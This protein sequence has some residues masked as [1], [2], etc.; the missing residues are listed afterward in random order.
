[1]GFFSSDYQTKVAT[2]VSRAVGD[3]FIPNSARK[4]GLKALV[5]DTPYLE[6]VQEELVN[7]IGLKAERLYQYGKQG[8]IFGL[9]SGNF[10]SAV[11]GR[12]QLTAVLQAIE[13]SPV[14]L[15]YSYFQRANRQHVV[16]MQLISLY[17]YNTTTNELEVL[18]SQRGHK[19]YL[20]DLMLVIPE[21]LVGTI[22]LASI[23]QWGTPANAAYSPLHVFGEITGA[24]RAFTPASYNP[25]VISPYMLV[26][27]SWGIADNLAGFNKYSPDPIET[28]QLS[29]PVPTTDDGFNYFQV[30]Y[31]VNGQKKYFMYRA[32]AG[33]YPTLDAVF[34]PAVDSN[35]DFFPF[36]YFRFNKVSEIANKTTSSYRAGK[37]LTKYLGINFDKIGTAI[38]ANPDIDK[39]EQAMLIMAV[40][41]V[42][43]DPLETRYLFS[44]FDG[45]YHSRATQHS[46][47]TNLDVAQYQDNGLDIRR[48][49]LVIQDARFKMALSNSGVIKRRVVANIG[50]VGTHTATYG[51]PPN[52]Q[53]PV[54]TYKHQVSS[55]LCDVIHVVNLT[56]EYDIYQGNLATGRGADGILLV[57]LDHSICKDYPIPDREKLYS[58]S[59]HY[60]FNSRVITEIKWYQSGLFQ[61]VMIVVAVLVTVFSFGSGVGAL[62]AALSAGSTAA[63][64]AAV[65]VLLEQLIIGLAI[66]IGLKL[67]VKS[68]GFDA[69]IFLALVAA[70]YGGYQS[71]QAGGLA[72][73][74]WASELLQL[75]SGLS[76]AI[77]DGLKSGVQDLIK[78]FESL[79]LLADTAS[80]S[81][82][83]ANKLLENNNWLS[84][85]VIFGEKPNDFYNRSIHSGNV[86]LISIGAISSYVDIALRLPKL[87]DTLGEHNYG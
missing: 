40:P 66:S 19:V 20:D 53:K 29:I 56:M 50:P 84:P 81:I 16:W 43:P 45:V 49:T 78:E 42:S 11:Q 51:L 5:Q 80:K 14:E 62:V 79:K 61:F 46:S 82:D 28:L 76:R 74:P 77:G 58:R 25:D 13:G 86:G 2:T 67:V 71:F 54:H 85:I 37:K 39:V 1:M 38:N 26:T 3:K 15:E 47:L 32:G 73:A 52:Q 8:Y 68:I 70:A 24:S 69:A 41:A 22:P 36:G 34:N 21:R 4:G 23:E 7:S 75:S 57:P 12:P 64:M 48:N 31:I 6:T 87:N 55:T 10:L 59:L 60:V 18:S 17:G 33:T 9:P 35:G 44:F 27:Y 83:A 63:V 65:L 72:G 30:K